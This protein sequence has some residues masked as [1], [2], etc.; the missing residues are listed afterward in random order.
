MS[1][2]NI[3]H[4]A[5]VT[6]LLLTTTSLPGVVASG[7]GSI[8]QGLR[9]DNGSANPARPFEAFDA[10][11]IAVVDVSGDGVKEI[12]THNDNN[13]FYVFD[14]ASGRL[15]AELE[16]THPPN[17]GARELAGPAVGDVNGN[18]LT[19]VV[20]TNSAGYVTAFEAVPTGDDR[21]VRFV[22]LW[23]NYMDPHHEDPNYANNMPYGEWGGSPGLDGPAFL[24]DSNGDGRDEVY[25]QLDN[26]PALYKLNPDGS[27]AWWSWSS[28]GNGGPLAADLTGDG[29]LEVF[30]PSDGG[31]VHIYDAASMRHRCSFH[32][33]GHGAWPASISVT[34]TAVDLTGD[35][36]KEVVFGVRDVADDR[37]DPNWIHRSHAHLFAVNADC[38]LVW[39]RTFDW[40]NPHVHMQ[41]IPLD[42]NGDGRLDVVFQDWNT[43]GHKPGNW[44]TTGPANLFALDGRSGNLL[45]RVEA[46]NYWSNKNAAAADVTG[47]G[48]VEILANRVGA[49]DGIGLYSAGGADRGFLSAPNGWV[50][51]RG[52]IVADLEGDGTL[53]IILPVHR[54][55]NFCSRPLDVGC[56]E[57]ALQIY[58][59]GSHATPVYSNNHLLN[60]GL[61]PPPPDTPPEPPG[62]GGGSGDVSFSNV[63]GNEWWIETDVHGAVAGVSFRADG[64]PWNPMQRTDWGSWARSQHV[65]SGSVVQFLADTAG[66]DVTSS[67]F[68]WPSA[69]PTTCPSAPPPPDG[70]GGSG[71][72]TFANARGNEWWVETDIHGSVASASFRIDGGSWNSLQRTDWGSWAR[73][74]HVPADSVVQF[75]AMTPGGETAL[76]PCFAWPGATQVACPGGGGDGGG[77]GGAFDV[78]FVAVRGNE[79]W[80]ETDV[81]SD[82]QVVGV[83]ARVSGGTWTALDHTD[84]G[85]WARSI[86]APPGS[87][88]E[89]RAR[90]SDGATATSQTYTWPPG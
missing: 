49:G 40:G 8:S 23:E 10:V 62:D 70:G 55:A 21:K 38:G 57:G 1:L 78:A 75:T 14:G 86:H 47:D 74:M 88:V 9:I 19:D 69:S 83:D 76:S 46:A 67:C 5:I 50:V 60:A 58:R 30:Y 11:N 27:P 71:D 59:T 53:E 72:L 61:T 18:G 80:I 34:P 4:A 16:T 48:Q 35:G 24:A 6:A 51:T 17:W 26:V 28:D 77:G 87:G 22:K 12:M 29:R 43:V 90:A 56:R 33:Q 45:W 20:L 7:H 39:H 13:R 15:L 31:Q 64:G 54:N 25:F 41:P 89:F 52:P 65:A 63:R 42:A 84:W 32:S 81:R 73:S 37:S 44:E 85:S 79:W 3:T 66:D 36:R 2:R 68:A 82:R